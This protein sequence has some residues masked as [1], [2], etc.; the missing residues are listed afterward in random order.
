MKFQWR[1]DCNAYNIFCM[2]IDL[3]ERRKHSIYLVANARSTNLFHYFYFTSV[4]VSCV[5]RWRKTN[6][7]FSFAAIQAPIPTDFSSTLLTNTDFFYFISYLNFEYDAF[8]AK[9]RRPKRNEKKISVFVCQPMRS[10]ACISDSIGRQSSTTAQHCKRS[11]F[12]VRFV[13]KIQMNTILIAL[14][15]AIRMRRDVIASIQDK[16]ISRV[17]GWE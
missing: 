15:A 5:E 2:F 1:N 6:E 14:A 16:M 12:V 3:A 8:D 7:L 17:T 11:L 13:H 9:K 10:F 4:L